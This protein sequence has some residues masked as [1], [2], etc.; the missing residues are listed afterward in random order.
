MYH[1]NKKAGERTHGSI[2]QKHGGPAKEQQVMNAP[3]AL[4]SFFLTASVL[5]SLGLLNSDPNIFFLV[6]HV[7]HLATTTVDIKNTLRPCS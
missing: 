4:T 7:Q 6:R 5:H 1:T 2:R 3:A